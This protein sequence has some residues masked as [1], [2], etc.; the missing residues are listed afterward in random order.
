MEENK[1]L[2]GNDATLE[3]D[4]TIAEAVAGPEEEL[5]AEPDLEAAVQADAETAAEPGFEA[6][7]EPSAETA[8]NSALEAGSETG[9]EENPSAGSG[10]EAMP[11]INRFPDEE[12]REEEIL[13]EVSA[14][15]E[16]RLAGVKAREEEKLAEERAREEA[17]LE[18]ERKAQ[19]EAKLAAERK[20][21]EE[22]RLA[23]ERKAQEEAR[24]A[25]ERKAQ[26]EARL[27]AERK[28]QEEAEIAARK[29]AEEDARIAEEKKAEKEAKKAARRAGREARKEKIRNWVPSPQLPNYLTIARI[30]MIPLFVVLI[31]WVPKPLGN[32]LAMIVFIIASLTDTADGY[33][34]RKYNYVSTFGKFMDPLADKLLVCSA[35]ICL[36]DLGRLESWI[37]I[38]IIAREFIISGFRL[39]AAEK[40]VVIAANI[41]GKVKTVFQM[42][43]VILMVANFGG[44]FDV[45]AQILKWAALIL[46]LI[47]LATYLFQ[48]RHVLQDEGKNHPDQN[49]PSQNQP[50]PNQP[51]QNG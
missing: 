13:A 6:A 44:L 38:I 32:I 37:V 34:A 9:F 2:F 23:A 5:F 39:V 49:Q 47:S 40:G 1:D 22:A 16:A 19:E 14:E 51:W 27:A 41:W 26:E 43:M 48:N 33:I 10:E 17:R 42:L 46:T 20:A 8:F 45:A 50:A 3:S 15:E 28:A 4:E 31:L 29:K 7:A 25:A 35:M 18:A 36:V 12:V 24:L 30:C 21:Q 11:E